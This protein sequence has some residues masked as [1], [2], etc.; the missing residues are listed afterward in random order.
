MPVYFA[1]FFRVTFMGAKTVNLVVATFCGVL[2]LLVGGCSEENVSESSVPLP[3][4]LSSPMRISAADSSHLLVSDYAEN[5]V[6]EVDRT[7]LALNW[8]FVTKGQPTGVVYTDFGGGR[9]FVGN[10]SVGSVDI[11]DGRGRFLGHLGGRTNVFGRVND[12]AVNENAGLLYV[13][14][15]KFARLN[16][17]DFSG[18][19][20]VD[21]LTSGGL[22]SPA[23]IVVAPS[24]LIY[25][26]DYGDTGN[27]NDQAIK[28][29]NADGSLN[30]AP[31]YSG[32]GSFSAPGFSAPQGLFVDAYGNLFFVDAG[33]G[34]ILVYD[35]TR[36]YVKTVGVR[37]TDVGQLY[38]PLDVFVDSV[39][40][41][42][43]VT[44]N[45]NGRVTV[46]RGEGVVP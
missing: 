24:G 26:S 8:C 18:N 6:C 13:L 7:T 43:F 3:Q 28:V 34:H 41:D 32:G 17:Y 31:I 19:V 12:L 10:K 39:N 5:K 2:F 42:I 33:M 36:T 21:D 23:A 1:S 44:D 40:N 46:Y 22:V 4:T 14:D 29:F 9:Y 35:A 30:G 16:V 38:Y 37:G 20:V 25:V 45:Q 11:F 27:F 15:S